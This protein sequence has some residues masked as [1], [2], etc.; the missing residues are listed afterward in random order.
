MDPCEQMVESSLLRVVRA[1]PAAEAEVVELVWIPRQVVPLPLHVPDTATAPRPTDLRV[2]DE[3]R[4]RDPDARVDAGCVLSVRVCEVELDPEWAARRPPGGSPAQE[5]Q[6]VATVHHPAAPRRATRSGMGQGQHRG[7]EVDICDRL[8]DLGNPGAPVARWES[9]VE[10]AAV[11]LLVRIELSAPDP[12]LS[13]ED[14][15]VRVEDEDRPTELS[16]ISELAIEAPYRSVDLL[17]G[18]ETAPVAGR[19]ATHFTVRQPPLVRE[20]QGLSLTSA[21]L[22]DGG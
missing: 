3:H 7:C 1:A 13:K 19:L 9:D 22:N 14:P 20:E 2:S 10:G 8:A 12:V 4:S 15:V 6:Q 18:G 16:E 5:R 21:S 11:G 17:E